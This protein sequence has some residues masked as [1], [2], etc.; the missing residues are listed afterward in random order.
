MRKLVLVLVLAALVMP[1][2]AL[3][4]GG[5]APAV[6][7]AINEFFGRNSEGSAVASGSGSNSTAFSNDAGSVTLS[8]DSA[9]SVLTSGAQFLGGT[10]LDGTTVSVDFNG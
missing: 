3:A 1:N 7:A 5:H 2:V 6:A 8:N 4:C 9:G 10:R